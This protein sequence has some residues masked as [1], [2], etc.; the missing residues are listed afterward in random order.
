M[1]SPI[2]GPSTITPYEDPVFGERPMYDRRDFTHRTKAMMLQEDENMADV[3]EIPTESDEGD[4]S[5]S[6]LEEQ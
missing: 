5:M 1:D 2:P 4:T 3:Y 6:M